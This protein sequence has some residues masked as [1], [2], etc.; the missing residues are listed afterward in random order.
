MSEV[1]CTSANS[2]TGRAAIILCGGHG[3]RIG[4]PKEWLT[5]DGETLLARTARVVRGCVDGIVLAARPDQSLPVVDGDVARVDDVVS[6]AGPLAG[7]V[8]GMEHLA[9][10]CAVM[11]VTACDHPKLE[12]QFVEGLFQQLEDGDPGLIPSYRGE[13]F[14]L[15]AVYRSNM[16]VGFRAALV[17][18]RRSVQR[19][20]IQAGASVLHVDDHPAFP[21]D[22]VQRSL[23]NVNDLATWEAIGRGE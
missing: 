4:T 16:L 23:L 10:R 18:G 5:I 17:E 11:F 9:G 15:T 19:V 21:P 12:P 7:I 6:D 2:A 1:R 3:R 22:V 13:L 8:A 14:P 20:A